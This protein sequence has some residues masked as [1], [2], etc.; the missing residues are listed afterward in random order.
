MIDIIASEAVKA[1]SVRST[2]V[3]LV[4][5]AAAVLV[6]GLMAL[7]S[8]GAW[9]AATPDERSHFG[10]LGDGTSVL[11]V[12]QLCLM[13]F[14][15]LTASSEYST[16][17]IRT[18]LVA[19]PVRRKL[20]LSKASVVAA[21]TLIA[22]EAI[23]VATFFLSRLLIGGRP[24]GSLSSVDTGLPVI[25]AEGLLMMV[26]A[27]IAVGLATMIRSTAGTLVTMAVL[28]FALPMLPQLLVPAP[29]GGR[30]ASVL[31]SELAGQLSGAATETV[32]SPLGALVAM[33]VWVVAA[34]YAGL[35]AITRRD[36]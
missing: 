22:G 31:P 3:L 8:A 27:L 12:V 19:V 4:S 10:G 6:G 36:A 1:R 24:I 14:G 21:I 20:L 33:A 2:R 15:I 7:I 18:S 30:I 13:A 5:S 26:V 32:L 29:W 9:D 17:M 23:A 35:V 16:G 11:T 25:L 34:L 28:L